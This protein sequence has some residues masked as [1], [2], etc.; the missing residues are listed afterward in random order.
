MGV[1]ASYKRKQQPTCSHRVTTMFMLWTKSAK[2]TA[3]NITKNGKERLIKLL[4]RAF[5]GTFSLFALEYKH[6]NVSVFLFLFW[7]KRIVYVRS[8]SCVEKYHRH[9]NHRCGRLSQKQQ[10]CGVFIILHSDYAFRLF[11][12]CSFVCL[13]WRRYLDARSSRCSSVTS[14]FSLHIRSCHHHL[15]I[16]A[17]FLFGFLHL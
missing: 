13:L 2:K 9:Q 6:A 15:Y 16:Y 17:F 11:F 1:R 7:K 4:A 12:V 14:V 5:R 3:K 10:P 8:R